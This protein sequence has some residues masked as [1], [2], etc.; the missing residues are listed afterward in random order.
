MS[1]ARDVVLA[2]DG[3]NSKTDLALV[4]SD[5]RVLG[6]ITTRRTLLADTIRFT[7]PQ[8]R[9]QAT[10]VLRHGAIEAR[11]IDGHGRSAGVL[12]VKEAAPAQPDGATLHLFPGR[13]TGTARM[14]LVALALH[15]CLAALVDDVD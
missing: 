10:V 3:G 6:N 2:V 12:E 7:G 4:G 9:R 1:V 8:G 11:I 5:G 15:V 13:L 14:G